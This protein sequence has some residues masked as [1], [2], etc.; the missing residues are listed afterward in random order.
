[1][2]S[3]FKRCPLYTSKRTSSERIEMSVKCQKRTSPLLF[4]HFVGGGEQRLRNS[5]AQRLGC[6]E[7]DR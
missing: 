3:P 7:I 6:F 1:M 2:R 4:D 5:K